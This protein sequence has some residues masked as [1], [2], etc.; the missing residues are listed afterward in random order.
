MRTLI[1]R[2]ELSKLFLDDLS[3]QAFPLADAFEE[4]RLFPTHDSIRNYAALAQADAF[5]KKAADHNGRIPPSLLE[6]AIRVLGEIEGD[7]RLVN[8]RIRNLAPEDIPRW[9]KV[10]RDTVHYILPPL[11][12]VEADMWPMCRFGPGATAGAG[13]PRGSHVLS[14][15]SGKQGVTRRAAHLFLSVVDEYFPNWKSTLITDSRVSYFKGNKLAF[16]PKD[17]NKCRQIAIEPSCNLFLQ[18]GVG[19]WMVRRLR[20]FGIDLRDQ[21]K[22]R[23]LAHL[24]S[25]TQEYA[26]VD[27]SD[28]SSRISRELVRY[29]LPGDWYNLLDCIRSPGYEK[30]GEYTAYEMFSSQGNA[31]T[32][33]L[34]TAIFF[35][36]VS[37]FPGKVSVYGDDIVCETSIYPS[38]ES[39]LEFCGFRV[40]RAKSFSDGFFRESCGGDYILGQHVRPIYYKEDANSWSD[41]AKLHN[42]L[43]KRWGWGI[44]NTLSYLRGLVPEQKMLKGPPSVLVVDDNSHENRAVDF[45]DAWFFFPDPP[46]DLTFDPETHSY[47]FKLRMWARGSKEYPWATLHSWEARKLAFLYAGRDPAAQS[48]LVTRTVKTLRGCSTCWLL[49]YLPVA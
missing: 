36:V 24:A 8:D 44:V 1:D 6:D 18:M 26:T 43:V 42:L 21:T 4:A 10:A 29:L 34:E 20:D 12:S 28:A 27:L 17:K 11:S 49:D 35:A 3:V 16:V 19:N 37:A 7:N 48:Q 46:S 41:V 38:V 45:V 5:T 23:A 30:E 14:K 15:I 40:N 39:A 13:G 9:L 2:Q 47:T 33:P 25:I 32:F 31:F 22:N